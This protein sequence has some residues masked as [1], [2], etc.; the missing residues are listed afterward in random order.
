MPKRK[1]KNRVQH[2]RAA[3]QAQIH[4]AGKL[5]NTLR[6]RAHRYLAM[7]REFDQLHRDRQDLLAKVN[8]AQD[9]ADYWYKA[10]VTEQS[11]A[12]QVREELERSRRA[13]NSL[14]QRLH[15]S[16]EG[17]KTAWFTAGLVALALVGNIVAYSLG[18]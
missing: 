3:L 14:K 6:K 4:A 7:A 13:H 18:Y 11:D 12:L 5:N 10:W 9:A 2:S 17:Q 15:D 16:R 1:I 8:D